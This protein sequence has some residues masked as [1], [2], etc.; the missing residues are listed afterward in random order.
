MCGIKAVEISP[1]LDSGFKLKF[2]I[3]KFCI[4]AEEKN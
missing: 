1:H 4:G 2:Y 3:H